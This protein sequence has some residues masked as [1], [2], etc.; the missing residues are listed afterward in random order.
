MDVN[1]RGR[2][3][4]WIIVE[5]VKRE[6]QNACVAREN[7]RSAVAVVDVE[8]DNE[9]TLNGSVVLKSADGDGNVVDGAEAFAVSSKGMVEST[10]DVESDAIAEGVACP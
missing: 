2:F 8:V 4:G 9:G 6:G 3:F 10:A 5:L 7:C 1:Y